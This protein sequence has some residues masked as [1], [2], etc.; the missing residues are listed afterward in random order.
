MSG[1]DKKKSLA[2]FFWAWGIMTVLGVVAGLWV[3]SHIMPRSMS[4]NMHLT[5]LTMVVFTVS[6]APV[7]AGI[8]A[9]GL[10]VLRNFRYRGEGIPP[11]A[12][13]VRENN[14]LL[15]S[16]IV[17]STVLTIFVLI[18]GLGA[19]AADNSSTGKDPLV[20]D[21]TGQ[22]W[23]WTFHYAGT[24]VSTTH[25][26]LPLNREVEF[27]VTSKDVTHGF[28]IVNMGVQ[29]D[30]NSNVITTIHTTPDRTGTFDIRCEQFCGLNHSAMVTQ[31]SVV[32]QQ[33]FQSW[34]ASAPANAA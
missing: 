25:L 24:D 21:V 16:W 18:W 26:I 28:W 6:A 19:L 27:R 33:N 20:V 8:Y 5:V 14:A 3:P 1:S 10:Y 4:G 2:T 12:T 29:V 7:A 32:S 30:A 23:L 13:P 22:Q 11:A 15:T 31:G 34:L 9:A 17:A